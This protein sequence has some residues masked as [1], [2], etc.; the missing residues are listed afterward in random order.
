MLPSI[1]GNTLRTRMAMVGLNTIPS[2]RPQL[3]RNYATL[4]EVETRLKSI[5]NIEKITKTMKIVASTRLSKAEKAKVS[6]KRVDEADRQFYENAKTKQLISEDSTEPPKELI[7]AI[8]SDKGLCGAIH[9][10]LARKVRSHLIDA[11]NADV[12]AIGDKI[13]MQLLRSHPSNVK[14]GINGVGKD[15]P[16]FEESSAIVDKIIT[17]LNARQYPKISIYYNDPISSLSFEAKNKLMFTPAAIEQSPALG[18]FDIDN[19]ANVPLDLFEYTFTN[20]ILTAMANGYAAEISARRNAMENASKN[21]GE[22]IN[23]YQILYNR[24]RQ[25]VITNEL[26]DIITGASI[27]N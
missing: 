12:V 3:A 5:K 1:F 19:D 13:R 11:P 24:T 22:M 20:Q 16:T 4:K 26:V 14:I 25:A 6:A 17:E 9:S 18:K 7:I 15:A 8:T 23:K 10:H 21:A 2:I 27:L